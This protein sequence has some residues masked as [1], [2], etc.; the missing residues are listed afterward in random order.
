M[1][2]SGE[3]KPSLRLLLVIGDADTAQNVARLLLR[4]QVPLQYQCRGHGTAS[5]EILSLCGLGETDKALTAAIVRKA[6]TKQILKELGRALGL[7]N[8]G[9]GIAVTVPINGLQAS[10]VRLLSRSETEEEEAVQT[11]SHHALILAAVNQGFSDEVMDAAREAGATG[12]T[13]IRGR[14]RGP[15]EAMRF[16]GISLQEEQELIAIVASREKRLD[17]MSAISRQYGPKSEAQGIV[18]SLPVEDIMGMEE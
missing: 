13:V 4:N 9:T 3:K 16:W 18:L 6:D 5:S 14:R 11:P 2:M 12:G 15:E 7:R 8:R 17:I 1:G 10:V